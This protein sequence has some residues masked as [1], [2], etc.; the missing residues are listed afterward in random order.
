[1]LKSTLCDYSDVYILV[2]G[3]TTITGAGVDAAARQADARDKG[4]F[5]NCPPFINCKTEI[6]N[7]EIDNAKDIDIVMP[8]YNLIE[9]SNNYSKTS[10]S[11]WQYYRDE[12]NDNVTDSESF[13]SKL[14][15]KKT[16]AEGNLKNV[17]IFV[18]LKYL[19][20]FWRT[21]AMPLINCEVNP[22]LTWPPTCVITNSTGAGTFEI[23][24]TKLYV[25]VVTLS[26][27][28]IAKFLQQLK[29]AF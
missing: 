9:Y 20:N 28:D 19:S 8:M 17:E 14:K 25:P 12:P 11:L 15:I 1:M 16:P 13:K 24:D 26:T 4:I 18:P 7:T 2:T 6:N 27:Q 23:S 5:K 10:G 22:I 3:T 29:S 21:L